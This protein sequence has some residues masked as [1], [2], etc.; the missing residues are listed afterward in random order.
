[1]ARF[2]WFQS[3]DWEECKNKQCMLLCLVAHVGF[4][5]TKKEEY[6]F[7]TNGLQ[8]DLAGRETHPVHVQRHHL[9]VLTYL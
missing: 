8:V 1:M 6:I 7:W 2:G 5:G 4:L 3:V 9:S